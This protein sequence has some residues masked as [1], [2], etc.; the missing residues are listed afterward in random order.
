MERGD[1]GRGEVYLGQRLL[2][3]FDPA[4]AGAFGDGE[5]SV[6]H[7]QARVAALM[8]GSPAVGLLHPGDVVV[9]LGSV[10]IRSMADLRGRLYVSAPDSKVA[11]SV[12]QGTTSRVVDV[13]L[14]ASP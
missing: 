7:A 1:H 2:D 14:G 3:Q 9:A 11:L 4:I 13:T 5:G 10:P 12:V 6:A 8:T